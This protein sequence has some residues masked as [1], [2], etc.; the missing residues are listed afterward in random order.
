MSFYNYQ[1]NT[2]ATIKLYLIKISL[3]LIF[4]CK[5]WVEVV[6]LMLSCLDSLKKELILF[7]ELFYLTFI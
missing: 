2:T 5:K 6:K 7:M 4:K 3:F 1:S